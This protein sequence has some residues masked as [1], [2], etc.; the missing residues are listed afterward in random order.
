M[1]MWQQ[2]FADLCATPRF[3]LCA[4]DPAQVAHSLAARDQM[5]RGQA[6][7]RWLVHYADAVAGVA[8]AR[9]C[10]VPYEDWF[11]RPLETAQRLASFIG[12]DEPDADEVR[13][14]IDPDLRHD[15][16]EYRRRAP[17]RGGSTGRYC[18]R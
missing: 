9:V 18:V 11:S 7:Y 17:W 16:E 3:V 15:Q 6:E 1:P 14:V 12:A 2:V 13:A 8:G 10:V 5:T 4:R